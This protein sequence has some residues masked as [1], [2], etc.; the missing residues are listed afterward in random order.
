M[1]R[2][3]NELGEWQAVHEQYIDGAGASDDAATA[4]AAADEE[5]EDAKFQEEEAM[6]ISL[7]TQLRSAVDTLLLQVRLVLPVAQ[8]T[9]SH[10]LT[11]MRHAA[12]LQGD[13]M[14]RAIR[15][16]KA[17]SD[18]GA[19]A[20]GQLHA[21][22]RAHTTG[23]GTGAGDAA[24]LIRGFAGQSSRPADAVAAAAAGASE[25]QAALEAAQG[26]A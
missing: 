3:S 26:V 19:R 4:V 9:R 7:G 10:Y 6:A 23:A 15:K 17:T 11:H 8:E 5:E 14:K 20:Y 18:A 1:C 21:V 22:V 12:A 25:A 13:T 16:A 2:L 24:D